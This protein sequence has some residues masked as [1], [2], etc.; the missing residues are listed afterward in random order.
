M[1]ILKLHAVSRADFIANNFADFQS[2]LD[3]RVSPDTIPERFYCGGRGVWTFQ[4]VLALNEFYGDKIA[5]SFGSECRP[6]AINLMHNDDFGSRVKPWKGVTVISRADRPPVVGADYVVEQ[7]PGTEGGKKRLFIPHWPQ[8]GLQPRE[9]TDSAI[10]TVAYF[11][12]QDSF[13]AELNTQ[14]FRQSLAKQGIELRISFNSWTNY[15]DVDVC[16][17]Y[18]KVHDYKLDRKPASKLINAWLGK[19]VMICDDEPSFR[20]I[21]ESELDYL[22]AKTPDEAFDAIM[23]LKND[24][25]LYQQMQEQGRKRLAFYSRRAVAARWYELFE[26]IWR[27]GLHNKPEFVRALHFSIGKVIRPLT[28]K[29]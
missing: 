16:L 19:T 24:P 2:L 9:R 11:G 1:A 21:R 12:S 3:N 7:N 6:D 28:K 10:K 4:T 23:R 27:K 22:I 18:R 20:A 15:R 5:Y 25:V 26:G 17:S 13:P 29:F 8:P 14:T